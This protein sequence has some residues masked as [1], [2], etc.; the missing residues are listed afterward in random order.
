MYNRSE[1]DKMNT[2]NIKKIKL[3]DTSGHNWCTSA[4]LVQVKNGRNTLHSV[5]SEP[6]DD[7]CSKGH[8]SLNGKPL[9][10]GEY[11]ACQ[12]CSAMLARGY[13]IENIN[14]PEL[15]AVRDK[16]NSKY[17]DISNAVDNISPILGLL[18]DG[19]YVIADAV[20][21]PTAGGRHFFCNVSD[22][23]SEIEAACE[24]Y[25]DHIFYEVTDGYPAYLYPSQSNC[26]LNKSRAKEYLSVID[27]PNSP[28]A[29][30]YH[31]FG[32]V[33][34]LLDGHHKAYAAALMGVPLRTLVV[35][36]LLYIKGLHTK[37]GNAL[38]ASISVSLDDL[39][40][41]EIPKNKPDYQKL[42][43]RTFDNM[44]IPEDDLILSHYPTVEELSG[45]SVSG[46]KGFVINEETVKHWIKSNEIEDEYR[47]KYAMDY[48]ASTD[49]K[50]AR[51]IARIVISQEMEKLGYKLECKKNAFR[52]LCKNKSP[53]SESA[54]IQYI[55][56][57]DASDEY[58]ADANS[59]W[60]E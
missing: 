4:M 35:I 30:A 9:V 60:N 12:T 44:P 2:P 24:E 18:K 17:T 28:R 40:E 49:P 41:L 34:V 3:L 53:E 33:N 16:I 47:V 42:E 6:D 52:V 27:K 38:F 36:P 39:P 8:L 19:Y 23:L 55:I 22:K 13:G 25:Y 26:C 59:Y 21:Y 32:F 43:I 20:V 14:A 31:L 57:H 45:Y 10:Q 50:L 11:P 58:W 46:I 56:D 1:G 5:Y 51:M 15:A 37:S 54:V 29:I 7:Y 48:Y